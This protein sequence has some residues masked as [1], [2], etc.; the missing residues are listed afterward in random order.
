MLLVYFDE[1]AWRKQKQ[2]A[3]ILKCTIVGISL[4]LAAIIFGIR[5]CWFSL[6]AIYCWE[7]YVLYLALTLGFNLAAFIKNYTLDKSRCFIGY[8]E[9]RISSEDDPS[10]FFDLAHSACISWLSNIIKE[11]D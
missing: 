3:V 11:R 6:Q 7:D 4:I 8:E 5:D 9:P 2:K 10:L 1:V